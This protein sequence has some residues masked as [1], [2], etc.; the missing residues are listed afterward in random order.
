M[1]LARSEDWACHRNRQASSIIH[2]PAGSSAAARCPGITVAAVAG[3]VPAGLGNSLGFTGKGPSEDLGKGYPSLSLSLSNLE[4]DF[5]LTHYHLSPN[6]LTS[7][8]HLA[9]TICP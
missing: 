1:S 7:V 9:S 3:L 4:S 5:N 8:S 6:S 2:D